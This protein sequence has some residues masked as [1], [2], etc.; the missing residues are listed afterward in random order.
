MI[1]NNYAKKKK[2]PKILSL[3]KKR[4]MKMHLRSNDRRL[5]DLVWS[6]SEMFPELLYNLCSFDT[7]RAADEFSQLYK[8]Q[9]GSGNV[10]LFPV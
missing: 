1:F 10:F 5:F 2:Y 3:S 8:Q 9:S 4:N 7:K 6:Y